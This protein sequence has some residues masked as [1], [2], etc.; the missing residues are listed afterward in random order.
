MRAFLAL[1]AFFCALAVLPDAAV[2]QSAEEQGRIAWAEQRGQLLYE[3]DRAAWVTTDDLAARVRDL[4]GAGIRG[5]TVERDGNF[6][7]V[8]YYVG[9]GDARAALYRGRVENGRVVSGEVFAAGSR[10]ALT[11]IQ[12]RIADARDAAARLDRQPCTEAHFNIT[13][14]PPENAEAPIDVYALTAQIQDVYPFGGHFR[15]TVSPSGQIVAQRA[16]T[17]SCLNMPRQQ[18]GHGQPAAL[19]ITHL[20]DPIPTEIHVFMSL[21]IGLPV[22]VGTANPQRIWSVEG[23]H[24]GLVQTPPGRPPHT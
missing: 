4:A 18:N 8:V 21:S 12:R 9:E 11:P 17:N 6:Y 20:L 3:V 14:I 2:A 16:F 1:A 23:S 22:Y 13:V 7:L 10:P 24:I 19:V 5:W 15:M